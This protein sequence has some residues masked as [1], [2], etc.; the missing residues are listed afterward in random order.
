MYEP[1]SKAI[2]DS[3]AQILAKM[4]AEQVNPLSK[5]WREKLQAGTLS[6]SDATGLLYVALDRYVLN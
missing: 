3:T 6:E 2:K 5:Q 1:S 4:E